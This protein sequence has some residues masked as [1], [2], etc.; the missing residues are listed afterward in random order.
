MRRSRF[1]TRLYNTLIW[2]EIESSEPRR[3]EAWEVG[4][5][6]TDKLGEMESGGPAII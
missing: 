3:K 4:L 6:V 5:G 1:I 2:L